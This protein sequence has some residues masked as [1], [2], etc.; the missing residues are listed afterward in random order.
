MP[1]PLSPQ[2]IE[3]ICELRRATTSRYPDVAREAKAILASSLYADIIADY[4]ATSTAK[5]A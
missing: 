4:D 2:L 3:A 5:D 1:R